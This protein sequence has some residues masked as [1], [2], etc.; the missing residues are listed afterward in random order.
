MLSTDRSAF[1]PESAFARRLKAYGEYADIEVIVF[2]RR[3]F[4]PV[5]YGQNIS[6]YP[7]NSSASFFYGIACL[8]RHLGYRDMIKSCL[9]NQLKAKEIIV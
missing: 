9:R 8:N 1:L 3:G 7:T 6:V 4:S 5:K 2:S